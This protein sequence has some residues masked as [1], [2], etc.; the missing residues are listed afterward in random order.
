MAANIPVGR[1]YD[2]ADALNLCA[3]FPV[4]YFEILRAAFGRAMIEPDRRGHNP[5]LHLILLFNMQT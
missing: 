3:M 1:G 5:A 2:P 4:L